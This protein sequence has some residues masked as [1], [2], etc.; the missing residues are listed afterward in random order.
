VVAYGRPRRP[1][2]QSDSRACARPLACSTCLLILA[3]AIQIFE[4]LRKIGGRHSF[5]AGLVIG[6][7][8]LKDEQVRSAHI[9]ASVKLK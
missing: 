3:Q 4:V 7:K 2:H 1:R 8:S 9:S 6:G 5:S